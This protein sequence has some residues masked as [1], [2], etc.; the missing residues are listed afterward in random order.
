MGAS[1]LTGIVVKLPA[2]AL[3]DVFGRR[4]LLVAG[5]LVFATLPFT[6]LAVSTLL[7]LIL[8]R[9]VHGRR[10]PFSARS[11]PRV[12]RMSRRRQAWHLAEHVLDGPGRR[13]GAGTRAGGLFD[14]RPAATIWR[15][16]AAGVIGL[17]VPII[18]ARWRW[19]SQ[20]ASHR[21][22][23]QEF[24]RGVAEVGRDRLV[25]VTSGAQAAQFVLNGM[26][27]AFLPLYGRDVLGLSAIG[28]RLAVRPADGDDARQCGRS[29]ASCRIG[30]A[31]D[32]SSS[33]DWRCAALRCCWFGR[34]EPAHDRDRDPRLRRRRGDDDG[35]DERVYHRCARAG[36]A[37]APRTACSG[38]STTS[39]MPWVRSPPG[40]L[41]AAVGY[42]TMFQVMAAVALVMA[43]AFAVA[44]RPAAIERV[45]RYGVMSARRHGRQRRST[46]MR[47]AMFVWRS[48]CGATIV[49]Q[50][51]S[52]EVD[53]SDDAVG[54]SPKGFEFG[55]TAK[56][57]APGKWIVQ[58]EGTNKY[59][60]Q[61]DADNTRSRFPVAV[62][63]DLTAADVDVSVRVKPVSG[64]VDQ[65]AGLVWR[66][67]NEDNYYIV[68]ANAL[69]NNVVLYKVE[70]G[71]APIS[72]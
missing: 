67:Q 28:A 10:R 60:A 13:P 71:N 42:A 26:L 33:P 58:A 34:N 7:A 21:A 47:I 46:V 30:R 65:A 48:F 1:T 62:V 36:H 38:R 44:S 32:G 52:H 45:A 37:T 27:N 5:A 39:A 51:A 11:L 61:V 64:R 23:W 72:R 2:G 41:V 56:A 24:K 50:A 16:I 19:T 25:L 49:L 40:L 17:G 66:F 59:L 12:S 35:C 8:L 70:K 68:R 6:Y 4:R 57:G 43:F 15:F 53:F 54:Q 9:F 55:H 69:E 31:A 22:P 20:A 14:R 3:S 18:V 63:R 29:S